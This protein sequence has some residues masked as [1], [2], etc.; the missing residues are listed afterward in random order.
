MKYIYKVIHGIYNSIYVTWIRYVKSRRDSSKLDT[1]NYAEKVDFDIIIQN[2]S[3]TFVLDSLYNQ[4][5]S[6][7]KPILLKLNFIDNIYTVEIKLF[8]KFNENSMIINA[9]KV[10]ISN[11][12]ISIDEII[13]K[14]IINILSQIEK[15]NLNEF[16]STTLTFRRY[17]KIDIL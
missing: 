3:G 11:N 14:I 1:T 8:I 12:N 13:N 16:F 7:L 15:Y 6:Q 2:T 17:V 9:Q 4:L 5:D 10:I